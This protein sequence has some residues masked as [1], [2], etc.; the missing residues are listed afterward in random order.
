MKETHPQ[1]A[2]S[3]RTQANGKEDYNISCRIHPHFYIQRLRNFLKHKHG[4]SMVLTGN[5]TSWVALQHIDKTIGL[6]LSRKCTYLIAC[7]AWMSLWSASKT[8]LL[9]CQKGRNSGLR[10]LGFTQPHVSLLMYF[11]FF[12][13]DNLTAVMKA[14]PGSFSVALSVVETDIPR[15]FRSAEMLPSSIK[16]RTTFHM[17]IP[18]KVT[19]LFNFF[20]DKDALNRNREQ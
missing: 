14:W 19:W 18:E 8:V 17:V 9:R 10:Q 1:P 11:F 15:Y 2:L 5:I 3:K 20:K 7:S 6:V 13:F 12:R 4:I 16:G